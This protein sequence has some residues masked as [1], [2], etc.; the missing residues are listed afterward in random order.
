MSSCPLV[1]SIVPLTVSNL[2]HSG[3]QRK[4]YDTALWNLKSGLSD[5]TANRITFATSEGCVEFNSYTIN[6]A[7]VVQ[8]FVNKVDTFLDSI[9]RNSLASGKTYLNG[10]KHFTKFLGLREVTPDTLVPLLKNQEID[11]Y[12]LLNE[13]ISYLG[14]VQ[15]KLSVSTIRLYI[16]VVTFFYGVF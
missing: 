16:N 12:T 9:R 14:Q 8:V 13:F 2:W 11:V 7:N 3:H 1:L 10:M 5:V 6:K 15:P 4:R